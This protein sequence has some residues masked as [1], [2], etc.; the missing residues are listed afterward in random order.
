MKKYI[1]SCIWIAGLVLPVQVFSQISVTVDASVQPT[2]VSRYLY[3]RNNSLSDNSSQPLAPGDWTRLRD[4][5]VTMLRESGGNNC[6]KYN[7]RKKSSSHPDW[8]NNIYAHDWDFAATS[9]QQNLPSAQG[10]WAFQLLGKAAKTNTA[11]FPDW[12]FNG[13]TWWMGVNQNLAGGGQPDPSTWS[14]VT[15]PNTA[16]TKAAV[17]GNPDLYLEDWTADSTVLLLDHWFNSLGLNKNT[18]RYWNMDNEVEI[19]SGTHDDVMPTQLSPDD[20]IQRYVAVATKARN[21]FPD[22][23]IVGPVTANEWQWYNWNNN[24]ITVN[25]SNYPWLEY[26]IKRIAEE[27]QNAGVR[28]LDVLDIHFYPES[29][30]NSEVVQMHRVFFDKDYVFPG[31]NGVRKINGGYDYSQTKEYILS[32]CNDWLLKYMGA[33]HNVKLG[34]TEIGVQITDPNAI[35]VWYA[36]TIGE[37]TKHPEMEIFTPWT[38]KVGMWEVLHLFS[39]YN[40]SLSVAAT[41]SDENTVSAYPTL[42]AGGD[43]LTVML[44]NRSTASQN[45]ALNFKGFI[46]ANETFTSLKLNNLPSSETFISHTANALQKGTT[47]GVGNIVRTTIPPMAVM[48]LQLR[49]AKGDFVTAVD[50]EVGDEVMRVFPVPSAGGKIHVIVNVTGEASLEL[51]DQNNKVVKEIYRGA[52]VNVPFSQDVDVTQLSSGVYFFRLRS[53]GIFTTKKVLLK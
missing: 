26:F 41:S 24:I 14:Q 23:K 5:G 27:Q 44:V 28:L 20:F 16:S 22:I 31:A 29:K 32:R 42:N 8:Y 51:V 33:N 18:L 17:E 49:G 47:N 39:R 1:A 50:T 35:A 13:S 43:S 12:S 11:N 9:L 36:G 34:V 30:I 25:G 4:A 7:W 45:V 38:W 46:L 10:M 53:N 19:W 6:S 2:A 15:D 48:C 40:K 21:A 37:F 52:I 3:G